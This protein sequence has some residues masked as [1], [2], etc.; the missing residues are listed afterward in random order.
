MTTAALLARSGKRVLV[1]EQ[2]GKVGGCCHSFRKEGFEFDT[3]IHYI[4]E[5]RN[6]TGSFLTFV[7]LHYFSVLHPNNNNLITQCKTD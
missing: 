2:H 7:T 6:K 1:L 5:M 3:G 4:G